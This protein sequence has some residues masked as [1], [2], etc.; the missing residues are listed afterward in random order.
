MNNIY[1]YIACKCPSNPNEG[2]AYDSYNEA[3]DAAAA[4]D[5]CVIEVTYSFEDSELV[6]D[7]RDEF[8]TS[9]FE[10]KRN[11]T[12]DDEEESSD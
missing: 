10:G 7:F 4:F 6:D 9:L 11:N 8:L 1:R 3:R 2:M 5:G 12:D